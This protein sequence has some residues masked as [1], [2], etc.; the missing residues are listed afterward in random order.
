MK[1]ENSINYGFQRCLSNGAIH[2]LK[3]LTAANVHTLHPEALDKNWQRIHFSNESTEYP[4][5][6]GLFTVHDYL[7]ASHRIAG[8]SWKMVRIP[9]VFISTI[10]SWAVLCRKHFV[11]I[12][13]RRMEVPPQFHSAERKKEH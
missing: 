4:D 5:H 3:D 2:G 11:Q 12:P 6:G 1:R 13:T 10:H 8:T 9:E 7:R